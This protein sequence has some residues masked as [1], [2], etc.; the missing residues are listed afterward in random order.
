M[1]ILISV[2]TLLTAPVAHDD[3]A[4]VHTIND[5]YDHRQNCQHRT[6]FIFEIWN[7]ASCNILLTLPSPIS[8]LPLPFN[9]G[10]IPFRSSALKIFVYQCNVRTKRFI[11]S[12][13]TR[14]L[15]NLS[16]SVYISL[17]NFFQLNKCKYDDIYC[18]TAGLT[19][20]LEFLVE[21]FNEP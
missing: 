8:M 3:S 10:C 20:V 5:C 15:V 16:L 9:H 17:N 7:I 21:N 6:P 19:V 11:S 4:P 2:Q 13:V 1:L 12:S 14:F 18:L